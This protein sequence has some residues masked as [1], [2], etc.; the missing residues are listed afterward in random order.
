MQSCVLCERISMIN[1]LQGLLNALED[2]VQKQFKISNKQI[3][4]IREIK[5]TVIQII[6]SIICSKA[7]RQS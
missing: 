7:Y 3:G 2:T 6:K 1:L 4:S 5:H